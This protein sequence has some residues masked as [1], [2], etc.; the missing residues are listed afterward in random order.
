[1]VLPDAVREA[2]L[3]ALALVLPTACVGCGRPDRTLCAGC[4]R[5]VAPAPIATTAPG[6]L[7]VIAGAPYR[8]T[9]QRVVLAAKDGRTSLAVPLAPLLLAALA[10]A[11]PDASVELCPVPSTRA[12][13]RRR[14][15]DPVIVAMRAAGLRPARLLR[16]ARAHAVQKGLGRTERAANLRGVHRAR[17]RLDGRRILLVDDVVT[18]GAT[19][20]EAARALRA[21]GAEVLGAVTIAATPRRLPGGTG[22]HTSRSAKRR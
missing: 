22:T 1:M 4:R 21:A 8:D 9:V 2:L 16:P 17:S 6:G 15:Y 14:G 13:L 18:T 5:R 12:A 20:A 3:D 10:H 7:R 11:A 19:L